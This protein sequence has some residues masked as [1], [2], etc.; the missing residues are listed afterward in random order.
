MTSETRPP[1]TTVSNYISRTLTSFVVPSGA[2]IAVVALSDGPR[3]AKDTAVLAAY[4]AVVAV[5]A[6][7]LVWRGWRS[8]VRFDEHGVTIR[9]IFRTRRFGWPEVSHFADG[10]GRYPEG[11]PWVPAIVLRD[12]RAVTLQEWAWGG[13]SPDPKIPAA[14]AACYGIPA[15]LTFVPPD[16]RGAR[17]GTH[18][19]QPHSLAN[20][21]RK[22]SGAISVKRSD[23]MTCVECGA[24]MGMAR[25][26]RR[27]GAPIPARP[28]DEAPGTRTGSQQ[29]AKWPK[30]LLVLVWTVGILLNLVALMVAIGF[31]VTAITEGSPAQA[32]PNYIPLWACAF[33]ALMFSIVPAISVL[34]LV[35]RRRERRAITSDS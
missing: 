14:I 8:G 6:I 11:R 16:N 9:K 22:P 35:G 21:V 2:V 26:C 33:L 32:G 3:W 31:I 29:A 12:G 1:V 24:E 25:R 34:F 4:C 13:K 20:L 27:C 19:G 28:Q 30:V 23:R 17:I 10:R 15:E 7:W 5:A 18:L